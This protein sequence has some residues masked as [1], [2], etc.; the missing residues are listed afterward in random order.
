MAGKHFKFQSEIQ[1]QLWKLGTKSWVHADLI[2]PN[3]IDL[4]E[5]SNISTNSVDHL[6]FFIKCQINH[7]SALYSVWLCK[8]QQMIGFFVSYHRFQVIDSLKFHL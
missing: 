4:T 2:I 1:R 5:M 8:S 6:T 3:L 7:T